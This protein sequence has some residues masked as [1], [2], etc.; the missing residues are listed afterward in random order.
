MQRVVACAFPL[1]LLLLLLLQLMP[2]CV[3]AMH[4]REVAPTNDAVVSSV[5]KIGVLHHA[6]G[7]YSI[8]DGNVPAL[9][10]MWLDHVAQSRATERGRIGRLNITYELTFLDA[11]SQS[12]A[13]VANQMRALLN[14]GND[15][16]MCPGA[17]YACTACALETELAGAIAVGAACTQSLI[18]P[19]DDAE[20]AATPPCTVPFTRRFQH[21]HVV[22]VAANEAEFPIIALT[23][24]H[25][26]KTIALVSFDES[27]ISD[28]SS[29]V[30]QIDDQNIEL[31]YR[32]FFDPAVDLVGVAEDSFAARVVENLERTQPDVVMLITG[33]QQSTDIVRRMVAR[34]YTPKALWASW[35][36][37]NVKGHPLGALT[38]YIVGMVTWD[39]NLSGREHIE[40]DDMPFSM[41]AVDTDELA[42]RH[43]LPERAS[44]RRFRDAFFDKV[45]VEPQ[46]VDAQ[47]LAA[48]AFI[49][50]A[51]VLT[52]KHVV[53]R[54][55]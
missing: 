21:L 8:F 44:P 16:I 3:D 1:L 19:S 25:G 26:A 9:S 43:A 22:N 11:A 54:Q 32:A 38:H 17:A 40:T 47:W 34:D 14:A 37:D 18:C 42:V 31:V 53:D 15:I 2:G 24:Q 6:T 23:A 7:F 4:D 46:P 51:V 48:F 20:L 39:P 12:A 35:V 50:A 10:E 36:V 13:S 41:F 55:A 29:I 28:G 33:Q 49:E 45:G 27:F 30:S 5:L 52:D